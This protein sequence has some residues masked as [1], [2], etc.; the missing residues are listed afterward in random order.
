M[1][2]TPTEWETGDIITAEKLNNMEQGIEDAFVAPAV[3][4]AD[5]GD[6]LTVNSSGE[7]VNAENVEGVP[8]HD[9]TNIGDFLGVNAVGDVTWVEHNDICV[10]TGTVT[11]DA[12]MDF[13]SFTLDEG[14]ISVV[15]QY[16]TAVL[17]C[18]LKMG[19]TVLMTADV[20]YHRRMLFN[21]TT[22]QAIDYKVFMTFIPT[23]TSAGHYQILTEVEIIYNTAG[24]SWS[25]DLR[26]Y[27]ILE[28][29]E[30]A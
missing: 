8:A 19:N 24:T 13:V 10:L 26:K 6:V 27:K 23:L 18:T 7:W 28:P 1:A 30:T 3:T 4:S 5:E 25:C 17:K 2:Y 11:V 14:D 22:M 9:S 20:P 21:T 16:K 15:D 29:S 12:N